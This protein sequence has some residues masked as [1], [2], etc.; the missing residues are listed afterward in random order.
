MKYNYIFL[1]FFLLGCSQ[2]SV[3]NNTETTSGITANK[4]IATSTN[5]KKI[6]PP[7]AASGLVQ[8]GNNF[9]IISDD[10][11]LLYL[12]TYGLK[13]CEGFTP[14][15][16]K[17]LPEN[18]KDRKNLKLDFESLVILPYV[19]PNE[20]QLLAVPS[21]SKEY[22][23]IGGLYV[24]NKLENKYIL[25]TEKTRIVNFSKLYSKL[26]KQIKK[27]NI[28]G[29][30]IIPEEKSIMRLFH[31]GNSKNGVPALID[32]DLLNIVN[33]INNDEIIS[34]KSLLSIKNINLEQG[35]FTDASVFKL[36]SS[37]FIAFLSAEEVTDDPVNDGKILGSKTGI[38]DLNGTVLL[39]KSWP[40]AV[41]AEGIVTSI[42]DKNLNLLKIF[43]VTDADNPAIPAEWLEQSLNLNE[44]E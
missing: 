33:A 21:G 28:E 9:F 2:P 44:I 31:R 6:H 27:L 29:A 37:T 24:L 1:L 43:A 19:N 3:V 30:V 32:L 34:D 15:F 35:G 41:K 7:S 25:N 4:N 18:P 22:R 36:N 23:H 5:N 12:C 17:D 16:H 39:E 20:L 38:M 13:S 14:P 26:D 11:D 40:S 10:S 8:S 42:S